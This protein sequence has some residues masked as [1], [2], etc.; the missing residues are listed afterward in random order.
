MRS[1]FFKGK[2]ILLLKRRMDVM[3]LL[4]NRE[5][6]FSR[7][8]T[9]KLKNTA[10]DLQGSVIGKKFSLLTETGKE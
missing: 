9:M 8:N 7:M 6:L 2:D 1:A 10:K 3:A 4:I 5:S